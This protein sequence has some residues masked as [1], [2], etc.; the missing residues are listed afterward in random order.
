MVR[1]GGR[2][3]PRGDLDRGKR[4]F[5]MMWVGTQRTEAG[6]GRMQ[7]KGTAVTAKTRA[8]PR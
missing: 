5:L 1:R 4:H 3:R 2:G 7:R 8:G 6:K